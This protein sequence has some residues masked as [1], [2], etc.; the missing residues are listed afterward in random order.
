MPKIKLT[1]TAVDAAQPKNHP[2]RTSR[3]SYPWILL[4]VAP[5][6]RKTFMVAYVANN[7]QRRKPAIGQF[8]ELTVEQARTIAQ[9]WLAGVRKGNDPSAERSAAR[10]R[11]RSRNSLT[12][13]SPIIRK[14][15]TS[16]RP[17]TPTGATA[18]AISFPISAT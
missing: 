4:K 15:K 6:G 18:N 2:I 10:K 17:S 7:G 9:D 1:K 8:G 13:S 12:D 3:H 5:T 14:P 16:H 11:R